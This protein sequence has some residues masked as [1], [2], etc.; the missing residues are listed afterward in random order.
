MKQLRLNIID[1]K[2]TIH[3][4]VS[5]RFAESLLASLTAEPEDILELAE[6][7]ARFIQPI[8]GQSPFA[9][10]KSGTCF[11]PY[12][13]GVFVVDLA[14]RIVAGNSTEV[15]TGSEKGFHAGPY[16]GEEDAYLPYR[17]SDDWLFVSSID[18]YNKL[19]EERRQERTEKAPFD[20][21]PV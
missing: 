18:E 7:L 17:P 10:F 15:E 4:E 19:R 13:D 5:T 2:E 21:R 14:A 20:A 1:K 11:E 6:A 9:E 12:D 3:N 8:S 16:D